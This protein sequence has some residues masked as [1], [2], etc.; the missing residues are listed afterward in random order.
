MRV[1]QSNRYIDALIF[2]DTFSVTI[3]SVSHGW[4]YPHYL[5]DRIKIDGERES[6]FLH[7]YSFTCLEVTCVGKCNR[8][9]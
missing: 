5:C 1:S 4:F 9:L 7:Y 2:N 3:Q 8:Y 6:R